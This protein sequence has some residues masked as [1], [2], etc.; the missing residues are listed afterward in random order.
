[1]RQVK[2]RKMYFVLAFFFFVEGGRGNGDN[3]TIDWFAF[4]G[5]QTGVQQGETMFSRFTTGSQCN[6][7]TFP[8][9]R[10]FLPNLSKNLIQTKEK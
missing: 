5:P 2:L 8:K 3:F 6:R 4:Q 1:M 10:Y 9:V 7:V